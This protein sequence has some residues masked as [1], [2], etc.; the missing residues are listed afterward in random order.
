MSATSYEFTARA[1][2]QI[3]RPKLMSGWTLAGF[4]VLVMIPLVLIF[5]KQSLLREVSQQ[6]LGDPL[7]LNYLANLVRAEPGN[8][9]LRL[10]LAEHKTHLG[11]LENV[12]ELIRP[13]LESD[14]PVW[15]ANGLLAEYKLVLAQMAGTDHSSREYRALLE[16][17]EKLF[18]KLSLKPWSLP[19]LVY[20]AGQADR[21]HEH[22][23]S[24]LLYRAIEDASATRSVQWLADTAVQSLA[25]GEYELAAH[26][27]F[28]ARHREFTTSGQREY[29][30]LGLRAL[31]AARLYDKAMRAMEQHLG[32]LA[33]DD[34]TLYE[35]VQLARAANDQGRAIRYTRRLLHLSWAYGFIA[36]LQG[37]DPARLIGI[38]D[39]NAGSLSED[40]KEEI[41]P[42]DAKSYQLAYEVFIAN[43]KLDDAFRVAQA[44]VRQVPE[45]RIWHKRL[46][47]LSEWL[48]KPELALREWQWLL[49]HGEG[50]PAILAVLRLAP[51]LNEYEALLDAWKRLELL[52]PLNDEQR[53]T[54][55][56]LFE[57]TARQREGIRYFEDRYA[58]DHRPGQLEAAARLAERNG[59]DEHAL[60]LYGKLLRAHGAKP[61]WVLR[62]A[63]LYLRQ[64]EYRKAYDLMERYRDRAG[65]K[66]VE[67]WRLLAD[68]AWQLQLDDEARQLYRRLQDSGK[69]ARDD[70]TR[71]IFL[72]DD[73]KQEEKAGLAEL[74]YRRNADRDMLMLALEIHTLRQDLPARQR[75]FELVAARGDVDLSAT[76]RFYVLR[77]QYRQA[78][79]DLAAA[80]AD[81]RHAVGISPDDPDTVNTILWFLID[82]HDEVALREMVGQLAAHGA[83]DEPVY[84]GALAAAYQVI[85][86]PRRA[87]AFYTRQLRQH[88]QDFLWLVNYADALEQAGQV[89]WAKQVRQQAWQLMEKKLSGKPLLLPFSQD[90][91]AAARLALL[92]HP[93]DPALALVRSLLRQDRLVAPEAV[94]DR[95]TSELV[96]AWALSTEQSAN[97]KAWL[98]QRYGRQV[99]PP[100][101]A[102]AA[103]ALAEGGSSRLEVLDEAGA[104]G[105]SRSVQHDA[106]QSQGRPDLARAV[107][108]AELQDDPENLSAHTRL[109]EDLLATASFVD[110]GIQDARFGSLHRRGRYLAI[111]MPLGR[112]TR[113]ALELDRA[114]QADDVPPA[115]AAV[116]ADDDISGASLRR[117]SS[118]G[119]TRLAVRRRNGFAQTTGIELTHAMESRSG[120]GLMLSV[121][122]HAVATESVLLREFGMRDR[123]GA[124][125]SYAIGKRD[126]LQLT[127]A[128]GRYATQ[129]GEGL[130]NGR[131]LNWEL[132]HRFLLDHPDVKVS[133]IGMHTRFSAVGGAPIS[134]PLDTDL[135]GACAALGESG[136]QAY[137]RAWHPYLNY[138]AT[139][140]DISG[141]GYNASLGLA[142]PL[143]G[144]DQ[145]SVVYG[146]EQGGVDLAYGQSHEFTLNYRYYFD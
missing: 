60:V 53:E 19:T 50:R 113:I 137:V 68:L 143:A 61:G 2:Q 119:D 112:D 91:L 108:F 135:F 38:G 90:M 21:L 8:L 26:L 98:W 92:N 11:D 57:Q 72:L 122:S 77:A 117:R 49:R 109:V 28:L 35:L 17:S 86:Q 99:R 46:A 15:Q 95:A 129:L 94:N 139:R 63:T 93:G 1:K 106:L 69:L 75:M 27:Y 13:A 47:Q 96:L 118:L 29:L 81:L 41:R 82:G 78:R 66:D 84:W 40:G 116:P 30:L 128:W 12:A 24:A 85:G 58:R 103:V 45:E 67:Y 71:L 34:A 104:D 89:G 4:A 144:A 73:A 83:L 123:V 120:I 130:G 131:N 145:L 127:T 64:S 51:G 100:Q 133:V 54:L 80:R 32:D 70:Y 121:E 87:L 132:A 79:G 55:L 126:Q 37:I 59:D 74:A 114:R 111:D 88:R 56:G 65:E 39:A 43:S 6:R 7:T 101:W 142:G 10:L 62:I 97:A 52:Q 76:P 124:T 134:L 3:V 146:R 125:L 140:N 23:V 105:L 9:E 22:G 18:R 115:Y 141:S 110:V 5:P 16:R 102:E 14:D 36:W 25:K 136:R 31:M 48:G 107:A 42:Y 138:C 33:E 20:L 44:A